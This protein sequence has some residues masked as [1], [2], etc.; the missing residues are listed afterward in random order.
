MNHFPIWLTILVPI[1]AVAAVFTIISL[2]FRPS[3]KKILELMRS[4]GMLFSQKRVRMEMRFPLKIRITWVDLYLGNSALA[5]FQP[6]FNI[7]SLYIPF[8]SA[9]TPEAHNTRFA[10]AKNK[11][12]RAYILLETEL[13]PLGR[14][15]IRLFPKNADQWYQAIRER[16]PR[17]AISG[18]SSVPRT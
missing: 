9:N 18:E 14:G 17:A 8:G 4:Q 3:K 7:R 1:A 2:V 12:G 11:K 13:P 6:L 15:E 16:R 10:S 5:A